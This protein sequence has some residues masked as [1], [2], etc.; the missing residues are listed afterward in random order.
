MRPPRSDGSL[1]LGGLLFLHLWLL[2]SLLHRS[3]AETDLLRLHRLPVVV[4]EQSTYKLAELVHGEPVALEQPLEIL[5]HRLRVGV[6]GLRLAVQ[7][8]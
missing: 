1:D 7:G 3:A 6:A 5:G 4:G 2:G 8:T